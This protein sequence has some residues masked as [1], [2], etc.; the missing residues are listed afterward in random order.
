MPRRL[1]DSIVAKEAIANSTGPAA[2]ALVG[3]AVDATGFSRARFVFHFGANGSSASVSTGLGVWQAATS[4]ATFAL[5][6]SA[7]AITSGVLSAGAQNIVIIDV[8]TSSGTPWLKASGSIVQAGTPH[9]AIVELYGAINR[10][11][12]SVAVQVVVA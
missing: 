5:I 12:T 9:G 11:P 2:A 8:P 1:N 4:G 10:P 6:T 3:T 7:N